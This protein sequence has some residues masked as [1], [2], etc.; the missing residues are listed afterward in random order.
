MS[1][2]FVL[3]LI[4]ALV[5]AVFAIQNAAAVEVNFLAWKVSI[6]QA[7]IILVSAIF[8]AIAVLLLS[9]VKQMKLKAGIRNDKKTITSLQNEN[10]TL[11]GKL[12]QAVAKAVA[13]ETAASE[14]ATEPPASETL[15]NPEK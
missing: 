7:L 10:Q 6:S 2:K 8:G 3:S 9:L 1:W 15:M 13:P 14:T 12:E 11:K 5:V 4:F